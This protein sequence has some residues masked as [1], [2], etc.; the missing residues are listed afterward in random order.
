MG[1]TIITIVR[2][3]ETEWNRAMQL[4][5]QQD[6]AL[7]ETGIEQ[8]RYLA[9]KIK[10]R[11]FDILICS[12]LYR[13]KHTASILNKHLKLKIIEDKSLRERSFGIMEG[14]TRDEIKHTYK[15]VFEAYMS[16]KSSYQIP[17]GESLIQFNNRTIEGIENIA[18]TFRGKRIL[19]VSHGGVLDCVM[20]KIFNL[21][22]D[23]ER[24]FSVYNTS[25]NTISFE[26]NNWILEEWGNLEHV[27]QSVVLNELN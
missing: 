20:R 5:G 4:Q 6:S 15:E 9:E 23:D 8:T 14:M 3:G 21:K 2:H 12:D 27:N 24:H 19:I 13:A 25:V 18:E 17:E 7:T 22:L 16:R 10:F 11:K 26:N 1:K